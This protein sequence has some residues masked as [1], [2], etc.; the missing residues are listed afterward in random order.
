MVGVSVSSADKKASAAVAGRVQPH[1]PGAEHHR[2]VRGGAA[3]AAVFG[4]SDGL[5]TNVSLVLGVA[6]AQT[7]PG[8]VRLAGVA[9]L[10]AG[11]ASMSAGEYISMSAQSELM[12]REIDVER[13]ALRDHPRSERQELVRLYVRRG[14]RQDLA[15]EVATAMMRDADTALEVHTREEL[16]I[17]PGETGSPVQ[18]AA[19]SL[20][21]FA[22]GALIPLFP[23]FFMSGSPA[24]LLSV[25]LGIIAAFAIGAVLAAVTGRSRIFGGFRQLLIAAVAAGITFGIGSLVGVHTG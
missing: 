2:D 20:V 4:I 3:R 13:R 22:I 21:A 5:L 7:G 14:L 17:A 18:A 16:G 24:I 11:A 10:V 9:G 8:F 15:E 23:W 12:E 6:A 25:G 1:L 19:S